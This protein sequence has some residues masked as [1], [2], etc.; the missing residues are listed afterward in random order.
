VDVNEIVSAAEDLGLRLVR[1]LWCGNDGTVR[2]KA[3][4]LAGLEQRMRSGIGVT[5]AMEA[6]NSLDQLQPVDG[7]G[8]VGELRIV[9]DPG[10]FRVLPYAPHTAAMLTD[11]LALDGTPAPVCQRSFLKRMEADLAERGAVLQAG[12]ENEFT[13][14]EPRDGDWRPVDTSLCFSTIG[15]AASQD[16][17]GALVDALDRQGVPVEQYYAELG[18]GQQEI[19][20]GHAPAL[21]AADDQILTRETIRGVASARGLA[22]SL[23]PKPWP[24]AAGNGCHIHFSLWDSEGARNRFYPEGTEGSLSS[25]AIAFTAGVLEHLPGLCGLTAPSFNS[26]RRIAPQTWSGAY[27]CWGYDN[28]EAPLRVPSVF[29]G[30]E[31]ASTNVEVKAADATCNPYLALGGLIAAGL[32]GIARGLELPEPVGVDPA[33]MTGTEREARGIVRLPETQAEALDAL[34]ADAVLSSALGDTLLRSY[35]AV[36]RSEWETYS[37]EDEEFEHR[38]HFLKY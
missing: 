32:D 18:H 8:P 34:E 22:A 1:F 5:L 14:A 28:R 33:T 11:Q 38:G 36:R 13:L 3:T 20:T 4:A 26:Y 35:L 30:I 19:T 21:R 17:A 15:M 37:A 27:G 2:A 10:T 24:D 31:E 23:A 29:R 7:M 16:Y 12:F 6:M 9:P 25:E